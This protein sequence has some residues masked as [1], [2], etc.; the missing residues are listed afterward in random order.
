MSIVIMKGVQLT[1]VEDSGPHYYVRRVVRPGYRVRARPPPPPIF[2]G[3]GN[4]IC[5]STIG[6]GGTCRAIRMQMVG[7]CMA[8]MAY[9]KREMG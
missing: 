7:P 2:R 6:R 4:S 9:G 8:G 1:A 3:H 5:A